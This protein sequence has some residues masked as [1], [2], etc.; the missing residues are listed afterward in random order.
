MNTKYFFC[1]AA[2]CM[3][4]LRAGAQE[5][6]TV[7]VGSTKFEMV[8]VQGGSYMMG[9]EP[10]L[11]HIGK[12][13]EV[14]QHTVT[15]NSFYLGRYEVTQELWEAVMGDNPSNF[16]GKNLPVEQVSYLE[17]QEFIRRLNEMTQLTFRLPTEAEWEYAA[18]G[19]TESK[20]TYYAGSNDP[21]LV[22]WAKK[23]SGDST[24]AV[25][26]LVPN[27]LGLYDMTGNVWEWCS[28]WYQDDYYLWQLGRALN[29]PAGIK[30]K[31][32]LITWFRNLY[33]YSP[34]ETAVEGVGYTMSTSRNTV[35][36]IKVG[37]YNESFES[38]E[39]KNPQ[40]PTHGE[41]R[42][43]R[44]G[45]WSD[46]T[47]NLHLSY[48]NFWVPNITISDLGF[49]LALNSDAPTAGWMPNQYIIDSIVG[50][51]VYTS[52]TTA[53][54]KRLQDGILEGVFSVSENTKIHFSKGNLQYNAVANKW[55]LAE[56]QYD[57][58]GFDNLDFNKDYPGWTDL[59]AWATSGYNN[60]A[61]YYHSSNASYYGYSDKNIEGTSYDWGVNN[62]IAN[63]GNKV[64]LWRTLTVFEW[65][66]LLTQ[67]P[68][69]QYLRCMAL[70]EGVQGMML[71]PDDW[72]QRGFDTVQF[73]HTYSF[74]TQRWQQLERAGA[75]FLPTTGYCKMNEF[76]I[77]QTI[78]RNNEFEIAGFN[79]PFS[80]NKPQ[81]FERTDQKASSAGM[82]DPIDITDITR[83][84]SCL[85]PSQFEFAKKCYY[86]PSIEN[87]VEQGYYWTT[88][89]YDKN[90]AMAVQFSYD[91]GLYIYPQQRVYRM[92][93]RLV[94]DVN[95]PAPEKH[96][97]FRRKRG[98]GN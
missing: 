53:A 90:T 42:V 14:P 47:E 3:G 96:S 45:S 72:L 34:Y 84:T 1:L 65:N 86:R 69:A 20:G 40:G 27:A 94:Q 4:W 74:T 54:K 26:Q 78:S 71:L 91:H 49:R 41:C 98:G 46:E 18:R 28:D 62:A 6:M 52:T 9:C 76:H 57:R 16:K 7:V 5:T 67:R 80:A 81:H 37:I 73:Y 19:G 70:V 56:H 15:L 43:G 58:I 83:T 11:W 29:C 21:M 8:L 95:A 97:F 17:V 68:D 12:N 89:H 93:V 64:G 88:V 10:E 30:T 75:V 79:I 32:Q 61:P 51:K 35:H 22:G 59:F 39:S 60:K 13:D 36:T 44:G 48:R 55:R 25:G 2:L 63:G 77:G 33:G 24:H 38:A 23:N 92:A 31:D 85:T 87:N 50:D 66:Y 82:S